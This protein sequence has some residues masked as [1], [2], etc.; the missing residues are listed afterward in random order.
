[1]EDHLEYELIK[2]G[3]TPKEFEE[4]LIYL[5][6]KSLKEDDIDIHVNVRE[7]FN[8]NALRKLYNSGDEFNFKAATIFYSP[9]ANLD[10][11]SIETL[12]TE[13]NPSADLTKRAKQ[14]YVEHVNANGQLRKYL[15]LR[16]GI[17]PGDLGLKNEDPRVL[18]DSIN[19][20]FFAAIESQNRLIN[21][22]KLEAPVNFYHGSRRTD[23]GKLK[24]GDTFLSGGFLHVTNNPSHA[25]TFSGQ[26][27]C[28]VRIRGKQGDKVRFVEG[29][30]NELESL[31][32]VGTKFRLLNDP[33]EELM[34]NGN[35]PFL[36][37]L[38]DGFSGLVRD[39]KKMR[40]L[41]V[42]VVGNTDGKD[43]EEVINS[44][45][46]T[47]KYREDRFWHIPDDMNIQRFRLL[48]LYY[49][50][51]PV[52][53]LL[54]L[55]FSVWFSLPEKSKTKIKTEGPKVIFEEI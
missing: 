33:H 32:P 11:T 48:F 51:P 18:P 28:V 52:F 4:I 7:L 22:S 27:C 47:K 10:Y 35:L 54:V 14:D 44:L 23:I 46:M 30:F 53:I 39:R 13:A 34:L 29:T 55:V 1:M 43:I 17:T 24:K 41:D 5:N 26:K 3:V 21:Q 19:K 36:K 31:F 45:P 49:V 16:P 25:L 37:F 12:I 42:E 20:L 8:K 9:Y 2:G 50:L 40:V 6:D 38:R 15:I